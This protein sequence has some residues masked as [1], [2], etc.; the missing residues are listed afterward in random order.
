MPML[1]VGTHFVTLRV[2]SKPSGKCLI[3]HNSG[4]WPEAVGR[5]GR[6]FADPLLPVGRRSELVRDL[7]GTGSKTCVYVTSLATK[8]QI[9]LAMPHCQIGSP[10]NPNPQQPPQQ[11]KFD[12]SIPSW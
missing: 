2:I 1:S 7:P 11:T 6:R 9:G 4:F 10:N 8:S 3:T 5:T 12:G